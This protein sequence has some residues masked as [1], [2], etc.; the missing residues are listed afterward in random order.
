MRRRWLVKGDIGKC[1]SLCDFLASQSFL[2]LTT[3]L[4][5]EASLSHASCF[6]FSLLFYVCGRKKDRSGLAGDNMLSIHCLQRKTGSG[7]V[8]MKIPMAILFKAAPP[9]M[10]IIQVQLFPLCFPSW[11]LVSDFTSLVKC[12]TIFYYPILINLT[13]CPNTTQSKLLLR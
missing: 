3:V 6:S 2:L 1:L 9:P 10:V 7:T 8:R 5:L 12:A 4:F 11:L 13:H